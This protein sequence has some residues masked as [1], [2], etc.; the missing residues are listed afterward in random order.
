MRNIYPTF[1][2]KQLNDLITTLR[3]NPM[4]T[5]KTVTMWYPETHNDTTLSPCHWSFEA[6]VNPSD[7]IG[8]ELTIKFNMH[9]VDTFLGLPMNIMYYSFL[10]VWLSHT[11]GMT[12]KGIIAD[13]T[14][15]HLYDNAIEFAKDLVANPVWDKCELTKVTYNGSRNETYPIADNFTID[16]YN[17]KGEYMPVEMLTYTN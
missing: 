5:K 2:P 3:S 6:L 9:S 11:T 17:F 4:A 8:Y 13:L 12:P 16:N 1:L 14:N 7:G 10:C 15:V